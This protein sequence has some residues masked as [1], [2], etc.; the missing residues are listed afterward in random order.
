MKTNT[1]NTPAAKWTITLAAAAVLSTGTIATARAD[2]DDREDRIE[3]QQERVE[4]AIERERERAEDWYDDA[5]D[6][7]RHRQRRHRRA[8]WFGDWNDDAYHQQRARLDHERDRYEDHL[9]RLEDGHHQYDRHRA[10]RVRRPAVSVWAGYGY[11]AARVDVRVPLPAAHVQ[12]PAAHA[13]NCHCQ[14]CDAGRPSF[15][16]ELH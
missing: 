16:F 13:A 6:T 4:D 1:T 14:H 15:R 7:L 8:N 11:G 2:H 10:V 12:L 3:R 5:E 9:D